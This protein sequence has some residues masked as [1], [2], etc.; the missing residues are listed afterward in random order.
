LK[1]TNGWDN[2]DRNF[3]SGTDKYGFAAL[4]G[5]FG[6]LSINSL[7]G[8]IRGLGFWW[9]ATEVDVNRAYY[10]C[11]YNSRK[12]AYLEGNHKVGG[13]N[14]PTSIFPEVRTGKKV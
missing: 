3:G 14:P 11:I 10:Y 7:Y 13:T 6:I 5:G 4:P 2:H 1:A 9:S 12:G 8:C